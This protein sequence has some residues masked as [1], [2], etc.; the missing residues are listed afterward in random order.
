MLEIIVKKRFL[1][2]HQ[3]AV[4]YRVFHLGVYFMNVMRLF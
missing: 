4:S 1:V 3:S 2:N